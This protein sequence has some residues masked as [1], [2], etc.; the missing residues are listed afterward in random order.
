MYKDRNFRGLGEHVEFSISKKE[1]IEEGVSSLPV[2]L[3][4]KWKD[5]AIGKTSRIELEYD[6]DHSLEGVRNLLP[7]YLQRKY[8]AAGGNDDMRIS[9]RIATT[10]MKLQGYYT[11]SR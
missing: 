11:R 7:N 3:K 10:S 2:I 8:L 4:A 1:G 5:N 6:E 9:S